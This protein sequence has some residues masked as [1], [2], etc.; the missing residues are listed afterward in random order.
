MSESLSKLAKLVEGQLVI[1]D[2]LDFQEHIVAASTLETAT[3]DAITLIDSA[4]RLPSLAKSLAAAAVVPVGTGMQDRPIIEVQ[5]VHKAF[6]TIIQHFRPPRTRHRQGVSPQAVID[7]SARLAGDVEV[8]PLAL[9]GQDVELAEGVVIHAGARIGAGC[10]IGTGTTV[11][12]NAVLYEDTLVGR[13]CIIHANAVLGAFGFGYKPDAK[14][15]ELSAQLGWVELGDHVEVGAGTTID[16][17]TYGPTVIG[18]GTK[19]DNLVMI[20]H[21]CRT[22]RHNMI[23][24]QVGVAGSRTT[25]EWVNMAGQCG[26]SDHIQI[27]DGEVLGARSGVSN[28]VAP[29]QTVLGGP[30]IDRRQRKLQLASMSKLPEMRKQVKLLLKRVEELEQTSQLATEESSSKAA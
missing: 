14:G 11:F 6:A 27:G 18:S 28:D 30:A 2:A 7:P 16:R 25:G 4:E 1:P 17:G 29:K 24:S 5:D 3:T 21:N 26:L 8:H 23:C 19:I 22:G 13:D 10:R 9:I 15:L 20:A 12:A